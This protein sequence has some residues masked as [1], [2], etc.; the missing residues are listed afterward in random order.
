M[1]S[2]F[3]LEP[4]EFQT[5]RTE[6]ERAWQSLGTI[7]YGTQSAEE[8]SLVFRRSLYISRD[9]RAGEALSADNVRIIRPGYGL[10]PKNYEVVLGKKV[11][12]DTP[13]GT[14]VSWDLFG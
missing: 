13:R 4:D 14:P 12:R 1:D 9:V 2:T 8:G 5:L 6:T 11:A 10:P 3:S 7:R